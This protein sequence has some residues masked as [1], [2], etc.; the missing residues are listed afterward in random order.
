MAETTTGF[1]EEAPGVK[2]MTRL[3]AAAL[4]VGA[5]IIIVAVAIVAVK[6]DD[7]AVVVQVADA[8]NL[9]RALMLTSELADA[10]AIPRTSRRSRRASRS[11]RKV[12]T[13]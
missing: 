11:S 13:R 10:T 1:L 5:L 7:S 6:G 12:E 3:C 2:S 4:T 8:K 9:R